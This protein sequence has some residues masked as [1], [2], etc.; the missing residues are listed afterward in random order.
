[1]GGFLGIA[2]ATVNTQI[3]LP[4]NTFYVGE[5]I[6]VN[7]KCDNSKSSK[8]VKTFKFKLLRETEAQASGQS[9]SSSFYLVTKKDVGCKAKEQFD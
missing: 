2:S 3:S 9:I 8:P 4:T 7:I 5:G 6:K 1:V